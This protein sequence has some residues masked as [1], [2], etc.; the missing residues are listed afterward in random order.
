MLITFEGNEGCGKSTLIKNLS[1]QLSKMKIAHV[2]TR[3]PGGVPIAES[4]RSIL[5][6]HSMDALTE[7]FLYEASRAEHFSKV[8]A[9]ALKK[10][11]LVLCDR[12]TDSTLAYQGYARG[13]PLQ[14]VR[15][16]NQIA[17]F[18][19]QPQFTFFL[20]LPVQEGLRRAQDPNRFEKSGLAFHQKVRRGFLAEIRKNPK[21]W[22]VLKAKNRTPEQMTKEALEIILSHGKKK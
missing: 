6:H 8:I 4:L 13:I 15:T 18:Q 20:D 19:T 10:G 3:E 2:T 11:K 5:L 12:F 21:R 22:Y 16:L 14:V 9:P 7:L 1:K 17:T